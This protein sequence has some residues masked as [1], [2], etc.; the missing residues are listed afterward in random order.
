MNGAASVRT[1]PTYGYERHLR[2]SLA[3]RLRGRDLRWN[4]LPDG[5]IV[6]IESVTVDGMVTI[7]GYVGEF[8]PHLFS[9]VE[10]E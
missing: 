3:G 9:I 8:A 7:A 2:R 5:P 10:A 6:R 4:H 1:T